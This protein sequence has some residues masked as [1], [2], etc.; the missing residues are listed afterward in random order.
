M[1]G[2]YRAC[3]QLHTLELAR[4]SSLKP[5]ALA[6][7]QEHAGTLEHLSLV[8]CRNIDAAAG[9]DILETVKVGALWLLHGLLLHAVN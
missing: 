4:C 8:D 3:A 9:I 2:L 6:C 5:K 1:L 7:I